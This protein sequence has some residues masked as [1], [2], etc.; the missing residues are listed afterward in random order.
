M[1][2][3][4]HH[5]HFSSPIFCFLLFC[6]SYV[7]YDPL[8]LPIVSLL[9]FISFFFHSKIDHDDDAMILLLPPTL[10]FFVV[11]SFALFFFLLKSISH[12]LISLVS[13]FFYLNL[14]LERSFLLLISSLYFDHFS[15]MSCH[16]LYSSP[17]FESQLILPFFFLFFP[18]FSFLV[19]KSTL[20]HFFFFFLVSMC[21]F[22]SPP[23]QFVV[24]SCP[25]SVLHDF[26][27]EHLLCVPSPL[28]KIPE[29]AKIQ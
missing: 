5:F 8:L 3:L 15:V 29:V 21:S 2:S 1:L 14:F 26:S 24:H 7:T 10:L 17:P 28:S 13:F 19:S 27:I 16:V 4:P 11:V 25:V 9:L 12:Q 22:I 18:F 23:L 6:S 20:H